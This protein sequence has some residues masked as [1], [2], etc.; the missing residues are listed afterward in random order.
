VFGGA[1]VRRNKGDH[2]PL[3][4]PLPGAAVA[5]GAALLVSSPA[6]A[7]RTPERPLWAIN[8]A[9]LSVS[10][11]A[12]VGL[13]RLAMQANGYT[14]GTAWRGITLG[15]KGNQTLTIS[16]VAA[17]DDKTVANIILMSNGPAGN[18]KE[19]M[20]RIRPEMLKS[21]CRP[22]PWGFQHCHVGS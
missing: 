17:R 9:I 2:M 5:L 19:I 10:Y 14:I 11:E 22:T 20:E 4:R 8:Q 1:E 16:C 6:L 12:C 15:N 7:Q 3:R 18:D 21:N 13:A